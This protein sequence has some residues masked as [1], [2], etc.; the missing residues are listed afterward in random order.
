MEEFGGKPYHPWKK[1]SSANGIVV[2]RCPLQKMVTDK[3]LTRELCEELRSGD[4]VLSQECNG[5]FNRSTLK[6]RHSGQSGKGGHKLAMGTG[7][8]GSR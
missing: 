5:S 4:D 6:L 7:N 1:F 2:L 3:S 8:L